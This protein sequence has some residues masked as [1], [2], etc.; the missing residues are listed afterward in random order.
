MSSWVGGSGDP[1]ACWPHGINR[2][3]CQGCDGGYASTPVL[4]MEAHPQA[5]ACERPVG[6]RGNS[7]A[8]YRPQSSANHAAGIRCFQ[9]VSLMRM[10][11]D[12]RDNNWR[13]RLVRVFARANPNGFL[14]PLY[15]HFSPKVSRLRRD[16]AFPGHSAENGR[17]PTDGYGRGWTKGT[18]P[19][20]KALSSIA[21]SR[22]VEQRRRR[23]G[24]EGVSCCGCGR[25]GVRPARARARFLLL[26]QDGKTWS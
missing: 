17:T 16:F 5:V 8:C 7:P 15:P 10:A 24:E 26:R 3:P 2:E 22:W 18:E 23:V 12:K 20:G 1:S 25:N 4:L 13:K 9:P 14:S 21:E 11:G 6:G 19:E